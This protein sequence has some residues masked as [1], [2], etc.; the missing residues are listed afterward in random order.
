MK[1]IYP[2]N[3]TFCKNNCIYSGINIEEKRVICSCNIN[4]DKNMDEDNEYVEDDFKSYFLDNIN[5]RLFLCYKLF[6][7]SNN[8]KN[9]HA[10]YIIL[11]IF[12]ILLVFSFIHICYS[13]HRLKIYMARELFS[14]A[15]N[16]KEIESKTIKDSQY[17]N[18]NKYSNPKK[19]K[20][21]PFKASKGINN[22]A[23]STKNVFVV[24]LINKLSNDDIVS[25]ETP[26]NKNL[27]NKKYEWIENVKVNE[28]NFALE[29]KDKFAIGELKQKK[30][31]NIIKIIKEEKTKEEDINELPF[32]IAIQIDNRNILSIFY[33]FI[34]E[35]IELISIILNDNKLKAIL[36]SEYILGLLINFFF[37]ALLYSDEVVSNKYR[38]NGHLDF[39]VSLVLSI[40]S[41]IV[42]S[43]FCYY[44]K[45][46]RG[47]EEKIK[48]IL[49]IKYK[50]R[51]YRNIKKLI[52]Y[53]RLKF[54]CFFIAQLII[55]ATCLY[56]IVIFCVKYSCSQI[57]LLV[58]YCYSLLESIITAFAITFIILTTRKIG[59]SCLNKEL[60][61]TSKY[62]N[63]KF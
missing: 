50:V 51:C 25:E 27:N 32:A 21:T 55:V 52:L 34:K 8:L 19:K 3:I 36:F 47:I 49:E 56:Y 31:K 59:L 10:F 17:L 18:I 38:N 60:Y 13:L 54:I 33:S 11:I 26:K 45:Y 53:L 22:K 39:I 40:L 2:H 1:D 4:S 35:K 5:Y 9:S 61:N 57:S 6:F 41:N 42:T 30:E 23:K 46:S 20:E 43:I 58:N 24:D 44:L 16:N 28:D 7:N 62:I 14:I 37:N 48:L 29:T 12:F 15:L 63:S